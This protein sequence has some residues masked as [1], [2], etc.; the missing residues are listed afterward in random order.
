[1]RPGL[2]VGSFAVER[3]L[4][5]GA[6]AEVWQARHSSGSPVALKFA[7]GSHATGLLVEREA[8][9]LANLHHPGVVHIF[10]RGIVEG[11]SW[12]A[13]E[14]AQGT[15][16]ELPPGLGLHDL[17]VHLL[18][19]LAHLHARDLLHFDI[20]PSN[21]LIGCPPRT[22]R[23][24]ADRAGVRLADFGISWTGSDLY[25]SAGSPGWCCPE[26]AEGRPEAHHPHA[27]IYSLARVL[28][29]MMDGHPPPAWAAWLARAMHDDPDARFPTAAHARASLPDASTP[30]ASTTS[31]Q[32]TFDDETR[33][34]SAPI[35]RVGS[36]VAPAPIVTPVWPPQPPAQP[37]RLARLTFLDGGSSL[38]PYRPT[39]LGGRAPLLQ[40]LWQQAGTAGRLVVDGADDDVAE[41]TAILTVWA[42][43]VG[44]TVT[45]ES[46]PGGTPIEPLTSVQLGARAR[47]LGF[48]PV[49][50]VR[51]VRG[52]TTW[53]QVRRR[54]LE[55][56]RAH[57]VVSTDEG[58]VVRGAV[59]EVPEDRTLDGWV[60]ERCWTADNAV[61]AEAIAALE[62][63]DTLDPVPRGLLLELCRVRIRM[64]TDRA[65]A[66]RL[67]AASEQARASGAVLLAEG[68]ALSGCEVLARA[69]AIREAVAQLERLPPLTTP[70]TRAR[71]DAV[72]GYLLLY[73]GHPDAE[74]ALRRAIAD[75]GER[76]ASTPWMALAELLEGRGEV[77]SAL[78]AADNAVRTAN[79]DSAFER[80]SALLAVV[81]AQLACDVADDAIEATFRAI[82]DEDVSSFFIEA[83]VLLA[84]AGFERHRGRYEA[85]EWLFTEMQGLYTRHGQPETAT[86][87]D[88]SLLCLKR[89]DLSS[90]PFLVPANWEEQRATAPPFL[91][92]LM[93]VHDLFVAL[94]RDDADAIEQALQV[95]EADASPRPSAFEEGFDDAAALGPPHLAD[96]IRAL[97][98]TT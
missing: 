73:L 32:A 88:R 68:L 95:L 11:R 89:G 60:L 71:R 41:V 23:S 92:G 45:V 90:I 28:E 57:V 98:K 44:L 77:A 33:P 2:Q 38:L 63:D 16:S 7:R 17:A 83:R 40:A 75:H 85:A 72:R 96:R 87:I 8:E 82:D 54:L 3:R 35:P 64:P 67:L 10:D 66:E 59:V 9:R 31:P 49:Q 18:D 97:R 94:G 39:P 13:L 43:E 56:T 50:A 52:C 81:R 78:E 36:T 46:A 76:F 91:A 4:G 14:L 24:E 19:A 26:Q 12:A 86:V 93:R 79:P 70:L 69:W 42:R 84:R 21:I 51:L 6:S 20:K 25:S 62:V 1:M 5:Q 74:A 47:A 61:L 53:A 15:L 22:A 80:V 37:D 29:A 27:D 65:T 48:E 34:V 55:Y 58:L 30:R